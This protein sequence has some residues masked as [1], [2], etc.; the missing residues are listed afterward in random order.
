M[1]SIHPSNDVPSPIETS[2]T[3]HIQPNNP[4]F[5][6]ILPNKVATK[7]GDLGIKQNYL[8]KLITIKMSSRINE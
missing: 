7:V 2:N 8:K 3:I 5:N 6:E 1:R 4:N